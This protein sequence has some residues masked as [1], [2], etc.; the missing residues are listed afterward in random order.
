[1]LLVK[2]TNH[3]IDSTKEKTRNLRYIAKIVETKNEKKDTDIGNNNSF[4]SYQH[5]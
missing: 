4:T 2:S 3:L 1:V 5:T